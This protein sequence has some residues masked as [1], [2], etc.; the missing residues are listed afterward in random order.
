MQKARK[1]LLLRHHYLWKT[2]LVWPPKYTDFRQIPP[3]SLYT[4][5]Q[6]RFLFYCWLELQWIDMQ[7][8]YVMGSTLW[9]EDCI[10]SRT[11]KKSKGGW[12]KNKAQPSLIDTAAENKW[13]TS[14]TRSWWPSSTPGWLSPTPCQQ[15]N[16][17]PIVYAKLSRL[18]NRLHVWRNIMDFCS[19]A[20]RFH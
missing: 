13:Y 1:S 20:K 8:K 2:S 10:V 7:V 17:V 12:Q 4:R 15:V 6:I 19:F 5:D 3:M 9:S 11:V 18:L 14:S 16:I